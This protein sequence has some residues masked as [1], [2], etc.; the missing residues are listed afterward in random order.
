VIGAGFSSLVSDAD[1]APTM[2]EAVTL[3][4]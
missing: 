3:A 1:A 2:A 4:A